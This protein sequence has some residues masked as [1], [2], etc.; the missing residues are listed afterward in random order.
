[1]SLSFPFTEKPTGADPVQI[2]P[3]ILWFRLPLPMALD[4]VNV[5]A[6]ADSKGWTIVDTGFHSSRGVELWKQIMADHLAGRP[7]KRVIV[8]HYHP[9][10]V[11]MAGWF[12]HQFG[13]EIYAT[14]VSW[15][16]A[17]MLTLDVQETPTPEALRHVKVSGINDVRFEEIKNSRP[18]NFADCVHPIPLGYKRLSEGDWIKMGQRNWQVRIGHGHAPSHATFWSEDGNICIGADQFLPDITSNTGVYASEPEANPLQE[19]LDSCRRFLAMANEDILVLPGHKVPFRKLETRLGELIEHHESCLENLSNHLIRPSTAVDCFDAI[20][21]RR[22]PDREFGLALAETNAH[23]NYLWLNNQIAK[24]R[25]D[26][27]NYWRRPT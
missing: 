22:I 10:H 11:G 21:G 6:L 25:I 8:S 14:R 15:L 13:A 3:G 18:F 2:E 17:R 19:W 16:F 24:E 23:L 9:D 4:H 1:M 26:G 20:F 7:I 5:Y 27:V 12:K